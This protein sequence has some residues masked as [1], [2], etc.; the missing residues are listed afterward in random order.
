MPQLDTTTFV[1]QIFW[2]IVT[3]LALYWVMSKV[4]LPR[5]GDVI[6]N[7]A[8]KIASDLDQAA[9]L[10]AQAEE[11]SAAYQKALADARAQATALNRET[12]AKLSAIALVVRTGWPR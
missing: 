1:G 5:V 3:F 12:A 11:V 9:K 4:A 8:T 2:L 10:K 7:R 6:A